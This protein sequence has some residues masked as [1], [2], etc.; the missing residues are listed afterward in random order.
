VWIVDDAVLAWEGNVFANAGVNEDL[1]ILMKALER[2]LHVCEGLGVNGVAPSDVTE[3]QEGGKRLDDVRWNN[4]CDGRE[5]DLE[6]GQFIVSLAEEI[7]SIKYLH[8]SLR[9]VTRPLVKV[10]AFVKATNAWERRS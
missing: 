3:F 6:C 10:A 9:V 2:G 4:A 1:T 8:K 5:V 7:K